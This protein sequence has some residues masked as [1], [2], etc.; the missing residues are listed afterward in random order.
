VIAKNRVDEL[1]HGGIG[2]HL[3]NEDLGIKYSWRE[4]MFLFAG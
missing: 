4:K 1:S 2:A 3:S